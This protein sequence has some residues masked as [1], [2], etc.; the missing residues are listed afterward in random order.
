[1][2]MNYGK[3]S[4][5]ALDS[6]RLKERVLN[7]S[8][9]FNNEGVLLIPKADGIIGY[10]DGKPLVTIGS[11]KLRSFSKKNYKEHLEIVNQD[12]ANDFW[13][14][15]ES[16]PLQAYK[17]YIPNIKKAIERG[18]SNDKERA[19]QQII[20][21]NHKVDSLNNYSVCDFESAVSKLY[22]NDAKIKPEIDLIAINPKSMKIIL[23]E[24]KC[25][26][27]TLLSGRHNI[28][29][30]CEDYKLILKNNSCSEDIK[31]E[32][33]KSYNLLL[34][35][36]EQYDKRID[37]NDTKSFKLQVLFLITNRP[38]KNEKAENN[39]TD[40]AYKLAVKKVH[41]VVSESEVSDCFYLMRRETVEQVE[42]E[43]ENFISVIDEYLNLCGGD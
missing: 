27:N 38:C 5:K 34:E 14:I 22:F 30:H 32:I 23:I 40:E 42:L 24:Y 29:K 11:Q 43:D 6:Y 2:K 31:R 13:K 21:E 37:E 19:S 41:N 18:L 35:I 16:E 25:Q 3:F 4:R 10:W 12:E 8:K 39:I 1:M 36:Y 17:K 7:E 28:E 26:I 20:A 9:F 33:I 15:F